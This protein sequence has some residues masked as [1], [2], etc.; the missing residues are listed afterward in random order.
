M[1]NTFELSLLEDDEREQL[2]YIWNLLPD[3]DKKNIT[4]QDILFVLDATDD[5]LEE[6]GLLEVDEKTGEVTYLDGDIDEA[7]QLD[8]IIAA[9]K[10]GAKTHA[11]SPL[12]PAQVQIILDGEMQFGLSK[13]WYTEEED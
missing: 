6:E 12:T 2:D 1:D 11:C 7:K 5:F 9:A 4:R 10:E 13:G 8:Y 3:E